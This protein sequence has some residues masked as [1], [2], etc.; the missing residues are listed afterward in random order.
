LTA[1]IVTYNEQLKQ[2]ETQF[3][4]LRQSD[5]E[6]KT[7]AEHYSLCTPEKARQEGATKFKQCLVV[8]QVD[9]EEKPKHPRI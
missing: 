8:T 5:D 7:D 4:L 3:G 1:V 2:F 6:H 9:G